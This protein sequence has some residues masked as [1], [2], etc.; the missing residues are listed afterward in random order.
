[1][2]EGSDLQL[3]CEASGKPVP[4]IS[5]TMVF[6]NGSESEVLH[7]GSAW[8]MTSI[9]RTNQGTYRCTAYNGAGNADSFVVIINIPCKKNAQYN[10]YTLFLKHEL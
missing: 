5:W 9:K 8:N 6:R 4:N 2:R 10:V 3:F 1:M 7:G